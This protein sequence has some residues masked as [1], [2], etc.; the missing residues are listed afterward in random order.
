MKLMIQ[1]TVAH[2]A[3]VRELRLRHPEGA[4]LP[5]WP[6]GAHLKLH[7]PQSD[8]YSLIGMPGETQEY[9]I[10]VLKDAKSRGGSRQVHEQLAAGQ[11]L[12][13]EGP[14]NSFPL[15]LDAGRIVLVAGGIGITPLHAMAHELN[16]Q[17]RDFELHYLARS[18]D[19]LVLLD[20]LRALPHAQIHLHLGAAPPDLAALLGPYRPG[21]TLHACGPVPLLNALR[22]HGAAQGWPA[23]ALHFESFGARVDAQDRPLRVHLA[24][25][26]ISLDV[27]LGTSILDAL[28]QADQ[29]VAFDCKRGECGQCWTPVVE[30]EPVHRDVCLTPAQRAGGLCTCVGWARSAELT[31]DL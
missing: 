5:A 2:G 10:A 14:F 13:V 21:Q 6:A 30:G 25:S 19:R 4:A 27:P 8:G 1:A 20:E 3:D 22:E 7:L 15:K 9:R 16:A 31:L 26:G 18:E 28:I 11:T 24:Q 29:F 23:A 17:G 12:E